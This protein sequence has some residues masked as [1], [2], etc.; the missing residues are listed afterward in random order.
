MSDTGEVNKRTRRRAVRS[1]GPPPEE[2]NASAGYETT[3]AAEAKTAKLEKGKLEKPSLEK[4]SAAP[5]G[6]AVEV[7]KTAAR[8]ETAEETATER[9]PQP[10]VTEPEPT[11]VVE[12]VHTTEGIT[13]EQ[14]ATESNAES[15]APAAASAGRRFSWERVLSAVAVVLAV[16][17]VAASAWVMHLRSEASAQDALRADYVQTA[18]QAMLNITN[19]SAD[20]AS[21]DI[22]RVLEVTSGDLAAEYEQRKDDYAGIV[23]KAEVKAQGEVVEAAIES[24]DDNTAIVLVAVKQ[25]LTNAGA[26]GPQQRQFRFRVT[27][28]HTEK[29]LAA[30]Q[31]EMVI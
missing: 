10:P 2:Q 16:A 14:S 19:I 28:A 27:I 20:T 18:K 8:D 1:E 11:E 17:V 7:D 26:E 25:T 21:E 9:I 29:G 6:K 12:V 15:E 5:S 23:Q 22:K 4:P 3:V 31:M 30:T 13:P 24:S